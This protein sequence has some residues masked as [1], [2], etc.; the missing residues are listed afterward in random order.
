MPINRK[1]EEASE[2]ID[3]IIS[4]WGFSPNYGI[5]NEKRIEVERWFHNFQPSEFEDA[6]L[7]LKKIEYYDSGRIEKY[8]ENLS[9]ELNRIFNGDFSDVL[10]YPLGESPSSSGG[11][12]LYA[13]R[14]E[15]GVSENLFPSLPFKY[16]K[17]NEVK[18]IV[19]FDDM[20]GSGNQ[21][22]KFARKHFQNI[23]ID[24]YYVT[25]LAFQEGYDKLLKENCFKEVITQKCLS[26][27]Y[28]CFS[29]NS[30]IFS[31]ADTRERIRKMC[32]K[33]GCRL[34][35]K[36]P[37]GYDN[38]Q[39]LIV[40]SHST[41]NNTLPIIWASPENEK[42]PGIL[43]DPV[44]KRIKKEIIEI[45]NNRSW[46]LVTEN[47][48][49][50]DGSQ[51][52]AMIADVPVFPELVNDSRTLPNNKKTPFELRLP[53][54]KMFTGRESE[55]NK[56]ERILLKN[57]NSIKICAIFGSS[58][59]GKSVLASHF[60]NSNRDKFPDGIVGLRVDGKDANT[61]VRDFARIYEIKIDT[62]DE[63]D[64]TLLMK[65]LFSQRK[66]LIIFDNVEDTEIS[67][68]LDPG[69]NC[70]VILT[71]HDRLLPS[72]LEIPNDCIIDLPPLPDPA[73]QELLENMIGKERVDKEPKAV[74]N[75][76]KLVGNMPLA[77]RII[78]ATLKI[79]PMRS[80]SNF[81]KSLDKEK[82]GLARLK[83]VGDKD[84][85]VQASIS[86]S[87][88]HLKEEDIKFFACISVCA[89]DG[90]SINAAIASS[91]C[92][93]DL[94][95]EHLSTLYR[96]CLLE[97][98]FDSNKYVIH[99]LTLLFARD[100]ARQLEVFEDASERHARFYI[101]YLK[102]DIKDVSN[103]P[104]IPENIDDIFLA[105]KWLSNQKVT[106][107]EFRYHLFAIFNQFGHWNQ[108]VDIIS[109]FSQKAE[110]LGN[111]SDAVQL[112]IQQVRYL[113]MSGEMRQAGE[114]LNLIPEILDKIQEQAIHQQLKNSFFNILGT[115]LRK[116]GESNH[117]S[118]VKN[119]LPSTNSVFHITFS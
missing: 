22:I 80:L 71:T 84:L 93:E 40:F 89:A 85:N 57:E 109:S 77:L 50:R 86:L 34:Y 51:I 9:K 92:D 44:W 103:A 55:L 119:L 11:N 115:V 20:I 81:E 106:D 75:I 53:A 73:S 10:F 90:F 63:R 52:G 87:L 101:N 31:D 33:H 54:T 25:L 70:A 26:D 36:H 72:S 39:A 24:R 14:K 118:S 66:A 7:I 30:E 108:A 95:Y 2:E 88:K 96:F 37:L 56:L 91:G 68:L 94:A 105:A 82:T 111:W 38:S 42:K 6:L 99:P 110:N 67:S 1:I 74:L 19:F 45:K 76:I 98:Q 8:I 21:A 114:T 28:R 29:P 4:K 78:G 18:S 97:A 102:N 46:E 58:G 35:P 117:W 100:L 116:Q 59:F 13:F 3:K 113:S 48:N 79:Q 112:R 23:N 69:G 16:L 83:I 64:A 5:K 17:L 104:S 49:P 47:R 107:Y 41:P 27:E 43:W 65:E 32:E 61:I 60:A 62:D 15:L 12:F